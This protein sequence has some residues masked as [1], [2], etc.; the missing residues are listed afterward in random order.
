MTQPLR[1]AFLG[2]DH[3]HGAAW[4]ELLRNFPQELG[5]SALVPGFGGATTSLEESL[6]DVPRYANVDELLDRAEFDAAVIC[7]PNDESPVVAAALAAAGKHILVEKPAARTAADWQPVVAAVRSGGVAFQSGYMWRYDHG[8]E[9]LKAMLRE[10]RFGRLISV[11]MTFVTSDVRRRGL[12]HYLFDRTICGGGFFNWL[13][14]HNLDLLFYLT[15]QTIVGVTARTDVFGGTPTDVEDGGAVILD[16]AG[17]GMATLIGGY[18][19]PRWA[20]ENHWTLRGTERWVHWRPTEGSGVLEI[21]GPQPQWHAMEE[22][23][24]LP[25]DNT[26]GYGGY[27]GLQLIRDWLDAIRTGAP[28]RNTPAS[29]LATLELLDAIYTA[30]SEGRHVECHIEAA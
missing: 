24:R 16:L 18:W 5:I 6:V 14:C 27:R 20:G 15:T 11:E 7:L 30:S 22:T 3:P 29:T 13:A 8:A 12:D 21:H 17:G 2:V 9:R 26:P 23:F 28:C 25:V 19:I 10:Q 4:R 1:I